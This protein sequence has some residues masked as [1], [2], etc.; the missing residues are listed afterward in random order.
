M[1]ISLD[2]IINRLRGKTGKKGI[3]YDPCDRTIRELL[4][5][6]MFHQ[7]INDQPLG[8]TG[9]SHMLLDL[10][11]NSF[12]S[13]ALTA[14]YFENLELL[15][16][17]RQPR[18]VAGQIVLGL[19]TGRSGSTS[20]VEVLA[21]VEGSC[22]TH[23]NPALISWVPQQNEI[24]FHIRRF[25][26]LS[27][28]FPLVADVSHWWI[29]VLDD[30][31][32]HFPDAKVIGV[33]RDLDSCVKSFMQIKGFG[34]GSYNHW[35]PYG[36]GIWAAAQWDPTYPTYAVPESSAR[37]PD[38]TKSEL[39]TRYVREYNEKLRS[40]ASHAP[41][42]VLLVRTEELNDTPLQAAIF[43]FVGLSGRV[44]ISERNVGTTKDGRRPEFKF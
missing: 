39:I 3:D 10:I 8:S 40:I 31:F 25:K 7:H 19:G 43:H 16:K 36:N 34:R 11:E 13:D 17:S 9:R 5:D 2:R 23:E 4:A 21:T 20:L 12:P 28:Y 33:Y 32:S 42:K 44:I 1:L 37:D 41:E 18:Q 30:V 26:R 15:L 38:G 27:Q 14:A 29:N 22:C 24:D 6:R 35:V